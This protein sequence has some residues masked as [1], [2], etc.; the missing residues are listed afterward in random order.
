MQQDNTKN[1]AIE[2]LFTV[3][4]VTEKLKISRW[5]LDRLTEEKGIQTVKVGS[6]IRYTASHVAQLIN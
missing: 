1:D 5:T 2:E 3:K 4:E 6:S